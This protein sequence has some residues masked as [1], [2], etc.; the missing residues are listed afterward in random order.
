MGALTQAD[1]SIF[2]EKVVTGLA[3]SD[4][5]NNIVIL[6]RNKTRH[7]IIFLQIQKFACFIGHDIVIFPAQQ[8]HTK[9]EEEK[10]S[11]KKTCSL[12][13]MEIAGL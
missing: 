2:N 8:S 12:S 5:L 1:I 11:Y 4:P 7:L 6:Q 13:K 10:L 3:L 9:R